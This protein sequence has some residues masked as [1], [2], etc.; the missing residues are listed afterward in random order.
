MCSKRYAKHPQFDEGHKSIYLLLLCCLKC[1]LRISEAI[2]IQTRQFLFDQG[3]LV[4]DGFYKCNQLVRTNYNKC[5]SDDDRKIRVVP[6]PEDF[7][8]IIQSYIQKNNLSENNYVFTC[9]C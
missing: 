7:L 5:G 6:V 4:V 2:A 3:M 8:H 1:G 9:K